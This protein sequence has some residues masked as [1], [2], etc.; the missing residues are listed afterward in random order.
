MLTSVY[1]HKT[2]ND[3]RRSFTIDQDIMIIT[4]ED[5]SFYG[6]PAIWDGTTYVRLTQAQRASMDLND[7]SYPALDGPLY[8]RFVCPLDAHPS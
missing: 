6:N 2:Q 5:G 1:T 8:L 4:A 7:I 3:P